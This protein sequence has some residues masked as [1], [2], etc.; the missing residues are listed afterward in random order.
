MVERASENALL[1]TGGPHVDIITRDELKDKLD[2]GDRFKLVMT[3]SEWAFRAK[4][5]PGSLNVDRP[6]QAAK[7][8]DSEDEIVVYCSD[9][10]CPASKYAYQAL[11]KNGY[12][13][14]RRYA[15]GI[16]DWEEA[17]YPLEGE[18]AK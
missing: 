11:I 16:S 4:H 1:E 7:M 6:D 9:Q 3:L 18:W 13:K 17:G 5:I 8:L 10:G 15:G 12:K 14:V 2:R